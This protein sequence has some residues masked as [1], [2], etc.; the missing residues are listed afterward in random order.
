MLP[1]D[2]V[3][4][5]QNFSPIPRIYTPNATLTLCAKLVQKWFCWDFEV[6]PPSYVTINGFFSP[7]P[8]VYPPNTTILTKKNS[9]KF[10]QFPRKTYIV[11]KISTRIDRPRRGS[12]FDSTF[13]VCSFHWII[14]CF[15][16]ISHLFHRSTYTRLQI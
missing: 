14:C 10:S 1:P 16:E 8:R 6:L 9:W 7:I 15:L 4:I 11:C 13:N 3:T 2:Y 12:A 5:N